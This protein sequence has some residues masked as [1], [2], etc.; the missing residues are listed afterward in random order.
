[1]CNFLKL[2]LNFLVKIGAGFPLNVVFQSVVFILEFLLLWLGN[3]GRSEV[4]LV[5]FIIY[6]L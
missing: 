4:P 3:R 5:C 1:M 2:P 6:L